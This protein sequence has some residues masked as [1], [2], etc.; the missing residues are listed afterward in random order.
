[1]S[2]PFFFPPPTHV[3]K[4]RKKYTFLDLLYRYILVSGLFARVGLVS[5][6]LLSPWGTAQDAG[7]LKARIAAA[8]GCQGDLLKCLRELPLSAVTGLRVTAPRFLTGVG[9]WVRGEP[10]AAVESAG[11]P[12]LS[13]QLII[14]TTTT[15]SYL[16][17]NSHEIQYGIE[18]DQRN[19]VL[20]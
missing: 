4:T 19:R 12:F 6:C 3:T 10:S 1:M 5:G 8:A 18:E 17:F 20:R 16:D 2:Y 15:E 11:D 13:S 9:P 7:S 14:G